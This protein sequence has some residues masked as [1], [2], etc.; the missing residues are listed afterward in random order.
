ME[1]VTG[2]L[3][4]EFEEINRKIVDHTSDVNLT[5]QFLEII[6]LERA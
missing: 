3:I 6:L 1:A 5:V 2:V 4:S